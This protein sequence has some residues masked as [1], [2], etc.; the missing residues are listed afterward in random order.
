MKCDVIHAK[1]ALFSAGVLERAESEAVREHLRNCK[2]CSDALLELD[3]TV[4]LMDKRKRLEPNPFLYTRIK[5]KL[6][7]REGRESQSG[8]YPVYKKVLQQVFYSLLL[9]GG[10]LSGIKLGSAF[11]ERQ[12]D[13]THAAKTT[14]YYFNDLQ[15]ENLEVVLLNE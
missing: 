11:E 5:E 12:A 10:V 9:V 13:T 6:A 7:A 2:N 14:E 1:L 8:S 15:Q 3:T 4:K